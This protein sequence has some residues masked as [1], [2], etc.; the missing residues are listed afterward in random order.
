MD[1]ITLINLLNKL[2][3]EQPQTTWSIKCHYQ[4]GMGTTTLEVRILDTHPEL[5]RGK[6]IFQMENGKISFFKYQGFHPAVTP[7]HITDLILDI[8][9]YERARQL[10]LSN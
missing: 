4:D 8:I 10:A 9:N 3:E 1:E 2:V 7:E 5:L 6:I